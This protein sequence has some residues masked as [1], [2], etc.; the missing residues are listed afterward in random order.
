LE[1]VQLILCG[2]WG[3]GNDELRT[4]H[5]GTHWCRGR[6]W[7]QDKNRKETND[8]YQNPS[9]RHLISAH[10][11]RKEKGGQGLNGGVPHTNLIS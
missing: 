11:G 5:Y 2:V 6:V 8:A 7:G 1:G 10:V 9:P 3:V 4:I